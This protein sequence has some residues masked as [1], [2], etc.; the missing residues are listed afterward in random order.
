M[1]ASQLG[2]TVKTGVSESQ[3]SPNEE[4]EGSASVER[5]LQQYPAQHP[6]GQPHIAESSEILLY[7]LRAYDKRIRPNLGG[8]F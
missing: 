4:S 7:L 2:L 1:E 6:G 5:G 3:A 8:K